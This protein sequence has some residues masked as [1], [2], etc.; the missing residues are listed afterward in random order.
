MAKYDANSIK[1]LNARESIR[2]NIGM[3]IGDASSHGLHQLFIEGIAN[4]IDEAV[5]GYGKVIEIDIDSKTNE[6][7]ITVSNIPTVSSAA[8]GEYV[9]ENGT[10]TLTVNGNS[11]T[12]VEHH[13]SG[14]VTVNLTYSNFVE[15]SDG[16]KFVYNNQNNETIT[17]LLN[18]LPKSLMIFL[19]SK[20]P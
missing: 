6:L 12:F 17:V 4:S 10:Y 8:D 5:G 14:D 19:I 20:I 2:E 7:T 3:Y 18:L 1:T 16:I 15:T 9:E 13:Y 11:I